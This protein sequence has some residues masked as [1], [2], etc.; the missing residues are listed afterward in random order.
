MSGFCDD[1][2]ASFLRSTSK[3]CSECGTAR[4]GE[5]LVEVGMHVEVVKSGVDSAMEANENAPNMPFWVLQDHPNVTLQTRIYGKRSPRL[6][7][8][9]SWDKQFLK[10]HHYYWR[11]YKKLLRNQ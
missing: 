1:C 7:R 4:S 11:Q 8:G 3:W 5:A 10:E 9:I 2:G 6:G